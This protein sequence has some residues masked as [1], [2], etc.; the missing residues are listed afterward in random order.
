VWGVGK[1]YILKLDTTV[2]KM[3]IFVTK[4]GAATLF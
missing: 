2:A 3:M 4:F 1:K